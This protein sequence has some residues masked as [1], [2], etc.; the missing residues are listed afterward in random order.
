MHWSQ[1][2]RYSEFPTDSEHDGML[3]GFAYANHFRPRPAYR[4]CVEDSIY[5]AARQRGVGGGKPLSEPVGG[6]VEK[7][8]AEDRIGV[9][10]VDRQRK[11]V[12]L[13][14]VLEEVR[15]ERQLGHV[16]ALAAR[17]LDQHG[18][19]VDVRVGDGDAEL[20]VAAAAPAAR[21]E[22]QRWCV[23]GARRRI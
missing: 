9:I 16:V 11:N 15:A 8:V 12:R 21:P 3:A 14:Q 5:V 1:R 18:G 22:Q 7:V 6:I 13:H 2:R 20:D 4:Y 19:V 10:Q 17:D 23:R